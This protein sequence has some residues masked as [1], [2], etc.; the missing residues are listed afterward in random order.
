MRVAITDGDEVFCKYC[1]ES[2]HVDEDDIYKST[3][4]WQELICDGC[5]ETLGDI[6]K[7]SEHSRNEEDGHYRASESRYSLP[8][9]SDYIYGH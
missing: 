9:K 8:S 6:Y 4:G 5:D 2:F 7:E 1:V 3:E